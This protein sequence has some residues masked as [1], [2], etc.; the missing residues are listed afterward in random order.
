MLA[1]AIHGYRG[2]VREIL[3][4]IRRELG[5]GRNCHVVATGG[6][7]ELIAAGLPEIKL[8]HPAPH[9]GRV[10]HHRQPELHPTPPWIPQS[11]I[12][13]DFGGT[14]IKSAIVQNGTILHRGA[15]IDTL[16]TGD[17]AALIEAL[18]AEIQALRQ[19]ARR[20]RRHRHR[21]ARALP[22]ALP[23]SSIAS[24]TSPAGTMC[25]LR[26]LL[27]QRTGLPTAIEN[28][29][30]AM[31]YAEWK[32]G[33]A[34]NGV[35]VVCITLGTGVGGGLILNGQLFRGS[36][37]GAG[38]VGQMSIDL[39][40]RPGNYGNLGALEKYVGNAQ[41][42]ARAQKLYE[43][44]GKLLP[45]EECSP[46][47]LDAAARAGDTTAKQLWA[48]IGAEIGT[49][50]ANVVWLLNPDAIVLGGGVARAGELLFEPIRRTIQESTMPVFYESL[51]LLPAELGNDAGIIGS[52]AIALDSLPGHERQT[53]P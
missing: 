28:D 46:A 32:F 10:A 34:R 24:R 14:T 21:P 16:R 23:A 19:V 42:A 44:A 37:L 45:L 43:A 3:L 17:S 4:Q 41:I 8:V 13:I 53:G 39:K 52:A 50:L 5:A 49:A 22:I 47:A 29:A 48:E 6:Y 9:A 15:T 26:D 2:L 36:H 12:G 20:D 27:Q 30:N 1:G 40:G 31:A 51:R 7:A 38:E 33:A 11:A 18:I 25:P 35:N